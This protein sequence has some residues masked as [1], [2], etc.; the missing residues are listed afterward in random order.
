M[1]QSLLSRLTLKQ[2]FILPILA[3]L[4]VVA[5]AGVWINHAQRVDQVDRQAAASLGAHAQMLRSALEASG[6]RAHSLARLVAALPV[7]QRAFASRE[8]ARLEELT[9][10][11]FDQVKGE[12]GLKQF[13]FHIPP[14]TSFYRVHKPAKHGDDLSGFRKTV[15]QVNTAGEPRSG[16]EVGVAGAGIRGVVPVR[17]AGEQVGSV[18]FGLALNDAFLESVKDSYGFDAAIIA[19]DGDGGYRFWART[20][21]FALEEAS[22]P[23]IERVLASGEAVLEGVSPAGRELYLHLAPLEDFSGQ[24][25]AAAALTQPRSRLMAQV[26]AE[27]WTLA[28]VA[29]GL[30]LLLGLITWLT[31]TWVVRRLAR[32]SRRLNTSAQTV[33]EAAGQVSDGSG[34]LAEQAGQ[35]AA[36]LEQSAASLEQMG[37]MSQANARRSGE[38]LAAG[39]EAAESLSEAEGLMGQTVQA[40]E[41]LRESGRE[42]AKIIKTIDEI[43]FQTNLL[44]LNAAVEAARAGEAGAGFAVVADEVRS[45]AMRAAE[46]AKDTSGLI[47]G[48]VGQINQTVELVER[49]GQAFQAVGQSNQRVGELLD[50]ITQGAQ[51]QAQGI[52]QVNQAV[53]SLDQL[54][55][56]NAAG[57]QESAA[58]GEK[59]NQEAGL[60]A[61]LARELR[62]LV[63][64]RRR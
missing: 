36:A 11:A 17:R 46:A 6:R 10:E 3:A 60:M 18:E 45:L 57:A 26:W 31:A 59:L 64:G 19:P 49:T 5:A 44:A 7:V 55:Q 13:Q 20:G 32:V 54:V 27:T 62:E 21:G 1:S 8:R 34:R 23:G 50:G 47:E 42:T 2:R 63:R 53:S 24:T 16:I 30:V 15:L 35:G 61:E 56:D 4:V 29:A 38:A 37:G 43:A 25:V 22:A 9:L 33:T 14:A 12:L 41:Q 58:S 40:M 52:D 51:E 48:S 28:A 39:R